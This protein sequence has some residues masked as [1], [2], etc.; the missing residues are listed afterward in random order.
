LLLDA[1]PDLDIRD[2]LGN[3]A[4]YYA[5]TRGR[6]TAAE[7]LSRQLLAQTPKTTGLK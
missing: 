4:L 2:D 3:T 1:N 7:L 5:Q 6:Y